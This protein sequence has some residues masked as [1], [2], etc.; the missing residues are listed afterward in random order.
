MNTN[1]S[2]A[3]LSSAADHHRTVHVPSKRTYAPKRVVYHANGVTVYY[4]K[5]VAHDWANIPA[6][7]DWV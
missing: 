1:N 4:N 5:I 6:S 7:D 2:I 3:D